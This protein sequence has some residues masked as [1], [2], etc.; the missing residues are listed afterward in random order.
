MGVSLP[1]MLPPSARS[2][3]ARSAQ[4]ETDERSEEEMSEEDGIVMLATQGFDTQ[5]VDEPD[6]QP[7]Q[8]AG[9]A[10]CA[11]MT[12]PQMLAAMFDRFDAD[13]DGFL[14]R[15][16]ATAW[17]VAVA[18]GKTMDEGTYRSLV[19]ASLPPGESQRHDGAEPEADQRLLARGIDLPGLTRVYM[20]ETSLNVARDYE[21][22]INSVPPPRNLNLKFYRNRC[23]C[24]AGVSIEE[25]FRTWTGDYERLESGSLD[26]QLQ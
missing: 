20:I 5:P 7:T 10:Q 14:N 13:A 21:T 22:V 16:E 23:E 17:G 2:P 9:S 12:E 11:G 6:D 25:F 15:P 19:Q 8:A 3:V 26:V 4:P 18:D 24:S 1:P